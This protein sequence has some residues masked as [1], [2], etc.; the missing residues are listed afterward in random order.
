MKMNLMTKMKINRMTK[1]K[2]SQKTLIAPKTGQVREMAQVQG[3]DQAQ[4]M[5]PVQ[6][7]ALQQVTIPYS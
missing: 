2:K 3:T 7:K 6:F 4:G 5:V 1:M